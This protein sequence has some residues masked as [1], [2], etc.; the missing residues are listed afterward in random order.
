MSKYVAFFFQYKKKKWGNQDNGSF[1]APGYY[2]LLWCLIV[3]LPWA[4][5]CMHKQ[6]RVR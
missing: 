4:F 2:F 5:M 6:T 1:N 3:I